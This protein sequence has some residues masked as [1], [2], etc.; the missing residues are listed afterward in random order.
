LAH[1]NW[2]QS[3]HPHCQWSVSSRYD[4]GSIDKRT[5]FFSLFFKNSLLPEVDTAAETN[6]TIILGH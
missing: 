2:S 5:V 4:R 6:E 3:N 1:L